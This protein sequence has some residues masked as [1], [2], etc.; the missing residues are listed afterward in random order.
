MN[1]YNIE[2]DRKLHGLSE[3][4]I[5]FKKLCFHGNDLIEIPTAAIFFQAD[6]RYRRYTRYR[7]IGGIIGR[8]SAQVAARPHAATLK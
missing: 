1:M 7:G 5:S 2:A 6:R 3:Y 4:V 8:D